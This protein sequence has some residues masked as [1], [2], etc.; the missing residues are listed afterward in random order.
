MI[1]CESLIHTGLQPGENPTP[2]DLTLSTV[3]LLQPDWK[4]LK[5]FLRLMEHR[6]TGPNPVSMKGS[7]ETEPSALK[8]KIL[9]F[10]YRIA[11][12]REWPPVLVLRYRN[13]M[14]ATNS[15]LPALLVFLD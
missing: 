6:G 4:P 14:D 1:Q 3:S 13:R 12:N 2:H 10:P 8:S 15:H 11:F 9:T 7:Q 5:R